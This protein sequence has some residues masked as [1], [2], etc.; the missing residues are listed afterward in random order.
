MKKNFYW[1]L[2]P[3]ILMLLILL[4]NSCKKDNLKSLTLQEKIADAKNW[5]IN[6]AK[7]T[8]NHLSTNE[9]DSILI[10]N[11]P[12]WD[13]IQTEILEDQSLAIVIPVKTNLYELSQKEGELNLVISYKDS[14]KKFKM[15]NHF[16][17]NVS[18]TVKLSPLKLYHIAFPAIH[19]NANTEAKVK[20]ITVDDEDSVKY[21]SLKLNKLQS[22]GKLK[23]NLIM[24][25]GCT[26]H[27][28]VET[29]W[30]DGIA[31]SETWT[32]LYSTGCAGGSGGEH[33]EQYPTPED[34]SPPSD[35][36]PT[37]DS[38]SKI[39]KNHC[40]SGPQLSSLTELFGRF[41]SGDGNTE[42]ACLHKKQY[43]MMISKGA[44][45]SFCTNTN[46]SAQ[47]SYNTVNNTFNFQSDFSLSLTN[48]FEHEFFHAYQDNFLTNGTDQYAIGSNG[49]YPNGYPNIEFETALYGDI[50]RDRI[51][52][53]ALNNSNVPQP[54]KDEYVVW[55]NSITANNTKYPKTFSDFDGQYY[56]FM[57]KFKQY[58]GYANMGAIDYN[59][60]PNS[61]LNLFSTSNCK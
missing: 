59:L 46:M 47:Q 8:S 14:D 33:E 30:Q 44:K 34:G 1:I 3:I 11:E 56:Y 7:N 13:K 24:T 40:L 36:D 23:E 50:I 49:N 19:N 16:K 60:K 18:D 20:N 15:L 54:I 21:K 52:Q 10:K 5:Y 53:D 43:D 31:V 42:W 9:G 28:W 32:Y 2:T 39:I 29:H 12:E 48:T 41:I 61:L 6:Q 38:L 25:A 4:L 26:H 45:F 22:L 35:I 57:E 58:S 17:E 37:L 51:S 55:L 27:F